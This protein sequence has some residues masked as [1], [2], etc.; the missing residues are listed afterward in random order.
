MIKTKYHTEPL[1]GYTLYRDSSTRI[2]ILTVCQGIHN[3]R[4]KDSYLLSKILFFIPKRQSKDKEVWQNEITI[5]FPNDSGNKLLQIYRK[6]E[7]EILCHSSNN[8]K[9]LC[10]QFSPWNRCQ[11]IIIVKN[12]PPDRSY[13]VYV[14]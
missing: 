6:R 5:N 8:L 14:L 13:F 11:L 10:D 12:K 9:I 3:R 1:L 2:S 4:S 7:L